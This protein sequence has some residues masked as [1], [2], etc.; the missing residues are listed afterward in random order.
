MTKTH[1]ND[2]ADVGYKINDEN[3][4]LLYFENSFFSTLY[5]FYKVI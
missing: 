1:I 2:Y 3:P 4:L 5:D